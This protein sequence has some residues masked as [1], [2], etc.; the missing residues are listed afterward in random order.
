MIRRLAFLILVTVIAAWPVAQ[1]SIDPRTLIN[2]RFEPFRLIGNVYYVGPSGVS[3]FLIV[4]PS[5]SILIDGGYRETAAQI[6]ENIRALGFRVEDVKYLLNSHVHS[7]H[8]G[9]LAELKRLSRATMVASAADAKWLR[10]GNN[11][12]PAVAVDRIVEDGDTVRL[13]DTTLT[14]NLT[15]G[16]TPGATTWTMTTTEGGRSYH[17]LFYCSTSLAG[18][19][20]GNTLYPGVVEDYE[21]TFVKMRTLKSDVFLASH[22][23]YFGMQQKRRMMRPGRPNPFVDPTELARYVEQSERAFREELERQRSG[24]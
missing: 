14:A 7:D 15:P 11:D 6:A 12:A 24:S 10:I 19:L 5:G 22:P 1:Q 23:E 3:S 2:Q 16:H 8:F 18:Q 20:V 4:T 17:V 13:G 21:R 9:G